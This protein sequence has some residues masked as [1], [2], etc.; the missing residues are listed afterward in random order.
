MVGIGKYGSTEKGRPG[1]YYDENVSPKMSPLFFGL[2]YM[3]SFRK[4][5]SVMG[6]GGTGTLPTIYK[7]NFHSDSGVL[8]QK[9]LW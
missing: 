1:D 2:K 5:A 7:T 9:F 8:R 4:F 3:F 6:G